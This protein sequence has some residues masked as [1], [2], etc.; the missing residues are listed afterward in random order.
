[1]N[2]HLVTLVVDFAKLLP[3]DTAGNPIVFLYFGPE[4]VLPLASFLAGA[5]GV[6]LMFW[7]YILGFIRRSFRTLFRRN[8]AQVDLADTLDVDSEVAI[9]SSNNNPA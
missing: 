4:T 1:M 7:R 8:K 6:I 3:W 9:T 2:I 5:I